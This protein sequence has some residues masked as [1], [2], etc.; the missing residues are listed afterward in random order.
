[1]SSPRFE[2]GS[3][4]TERERSTNWAINHWLFLHLIGPLIRKI[5]DQGMFSWQAERGGKAVL[6]WKEQQLNKLK[7]K[8]PKEVYLVTRI[9][10]S[11]CSMIWS[12]FFHLQ[13]VLRVSSADETTRK[14]SSEFSPSWINNTF[15]SRMKR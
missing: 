9:A 7:K 3:F 11:N 2:P 1:M 13:K 4:M 10:R 15:S 8:C 5:L 12:W 6:R 14:T